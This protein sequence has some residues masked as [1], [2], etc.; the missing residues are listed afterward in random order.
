MIVGSID[1][2]PEGFTL[3][4]VPRAPMPSEVLLCRPEFFEVREVKNAFMDG[5]VGTVNRSTAMLQWE[6]LRETFERCGVRTQVLPAVPDCE[7]MVFTANPSFN[8]RASDGR[9]TCV[10][11]RMA[12]ASRA[13]EVDAHRR[14]FQENGYAIAE[15][16]EA[17]ERFEGG[18]DAI[19][20]PGRA[21]I[22][23]GAGARTSAAAHEAL[24]GI[25]N[26]PVISLQPTDPR[27]YHFDTCFCALSERAVMIFAQAFDAPAL[28]L[29]H[30]LFDVVIH[31]DESDAEGFACNAAAFFGTTVVI[32]KGAARTIAQ[33]RNL[34]FRVCEVETG[35]FMK[36]GGSVFC[37]KGELH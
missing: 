26:V 7:D 18:G 19:W 2:L 11:S 27:F 35:E 20:H 34:G 29:I 1:D 12:F 13:P 21:L 3:G 24:S 37:M 10:P 23:A 16:P 33:L 32:Q 36:S 30:H 4:N 25:F 5:R 9:R 6:R 8:G 14:W 28:A 22:W 17:V 31:V 15:M